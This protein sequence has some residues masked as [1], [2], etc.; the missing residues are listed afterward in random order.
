MTSPVNRRPARAVLRRR[1]LALGLA[2]LGTLALLLA[3]CGGSGRS[4][5]VSST[6]AS[7]AGSSSGA[8]SNAT[9]GDTGTAGAPRTTASTV[10]GGGGTASRCY[11]GSGAAKPDGAPPS[12]Y[13]STDAFGEVW[14][15]GK[16]LAQYDGSSS[17]P[18]KGCETPHV[19][20]QTFDG[21]PLDLTRSGEPTVIVYFAHWCP[22]CNREVPL[23]VKWLDE[24]GAPAGVR[25]VGV[26][27]GSRK[28]A[29]N[30]P[31]R[32]WLKKL[33]WSQPTVADDQ[34]GTAA[35]AL[36][37][38]AYPYFV[39][40]DADGSVFFRQEG[41]WDVA[42]FAAKVADLRRASAGPASS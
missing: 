17:D 1:P 12:S 9:D 30:F 31:P 18:A 40:L 42:Q 13:P 34:D 11:A 36:G 8:P 5:A 16:P 24:H 21:K 20:G 10:A 27:T 23:L 37:L 6:S 22:H 15:S 26:A 19:V 3:A 4:H 38:A 41:E 7:G 35:S 2:V 32:T 33:G 25:V 28:Q 39:F 14:V 29:P